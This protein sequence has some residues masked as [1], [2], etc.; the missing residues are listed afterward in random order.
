MS[1]TT[2]SGV[3]K[4]TPITTH[5]PV[6]NDKIDVVTSSVTTSQD[7]KNVSVNDTSN[8]DNNSDSMSET[9]VV[10]KAIEGFDLQSTENNIKRGKQSN[11]I[12]VNQYNKQSIEV[13]PYES[14]SF[15]NFFGLL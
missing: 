12:P 3:G 14:S 5:T 11:S 15:S 9:N 1:T 2:T 6:P 7:A 8:S 13:D 4:N 10:T